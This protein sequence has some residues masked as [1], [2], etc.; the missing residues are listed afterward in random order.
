MSQAQLYFFSESTNADFGQFLGW[1]MSRTPICSSGVLWGKGDES[2]LE[3]INPSIAPSVSNWAL[4]L[5][6]RL[7]MSR[8]PLVEPS[9]DQALVLGSQE[10]GG[11]CS[12]LSWQEPVLNPT[13]S[14]WPKQVAYSVNGFL[15]LQLHLILVFYKFFVSSFS[16]LSSVIFT[17]SSIW[18]IK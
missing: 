18:L 8:E 17:L 4:G 5:R 10:F 11:V 16:R 9:L 3:K 1:C 2:L 13:R 7:C 15:H 6:H 12:G 14:S